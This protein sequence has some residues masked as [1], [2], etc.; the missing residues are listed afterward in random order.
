MYFTNNISGFKYKSK[1]TV[2]ILW[3]LLIKFSV[4]LFKKVFTNCFRGW[5]H[6]VE[7]QYAV[8]I[9]ALS[10]LCS[11]PI[12]DRCLL[13]ALIGLLANLNL[14]PEVIS[15]LSRY[16]R[17][18]WFILAFFIFVFSI[19]KYKKYMFSIKY[20]MQICKFIMLTI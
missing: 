2:M 4:K 20:Q 14:E 5:R 19:I 15:N 12:M 9:V 17:R 13:V 16:R 18:S 3:N 11:L 8:F 6:Y 7:S 10:L 1:T